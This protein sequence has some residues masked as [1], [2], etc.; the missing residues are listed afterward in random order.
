MNLLPSGPESLSFHLYTYVTF[1]PGLYTLLHYLSKLELEKRFGQVLID[2]SPNCCRPKEEKEEVERKGGNQ[3]RGASYNYLCLIISIIV[4]WTK[5]L[6][7]VEIPASVGQKWCMNEGWWREWEIIYPIAKIRP[8]RNE[9]ADKKPLVK[10]SVIF[11]F[12]DDETLLLTQSSHCVIAP[13]LI[14]SLRPLS[15]S[16]KGNTKNAKNIDPLKPLV[17]GYSK[18]EE[19]SLNLQK[20]KVH[21]I[22]E[23]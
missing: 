18:I 22:A 4:F 10:I 16:G 7:G 9:V 12:M 5:I 17:L 2:I 21:F 6:D 15:N 3:N 11:S 13:T 23:S 8:S 20:F 14:I 19:L 1:T